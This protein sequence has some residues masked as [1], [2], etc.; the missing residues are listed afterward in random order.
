[1]F[2]R[3]HTNELCYFVTSSA[4]TVQPLRQKEFVRVAVLLAAHC[5]DELLQFDDDAVQGHLYCGEPVAAIALI[6]VARAGEMSRAWLQLSGCRA[7]F[8]EA[9]GQSLSETPKRVC[10]VAQKLAFF[11]SQGDTPLLAADPSKFVPQGG[12]TVAF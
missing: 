11:V 1:M 3:A 2:A 7:A 12:N 6:L 5:G 9:F 8:L 4:A 10:G